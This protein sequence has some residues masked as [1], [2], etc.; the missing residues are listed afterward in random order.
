MG[1][2][3]YINGIF[4]FL[5]CLLILIKLGAYDYLFTYFMGLGAGASPLI[6]VYILNLGLKYYDALF[7]LPIYHAS[8]IIAAVS[9]SAALF[10]DLAIISQFERHMYFLGISFI[11]AGVVL[12]SQHE[13]VGTEEERL[14][15][16]ES[17]GYLST[18]CE[19]T[20]VTVGE[21]RTLTVEG[22]KICV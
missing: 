5:K 14:R 10:D 7:I 21:G 20:S 17:E 8:F 6:G 16:L 11:F 12:V 9:S 3:G 15:L 19:D 13:E 2:A 18:H 4:I 1:L 22:E